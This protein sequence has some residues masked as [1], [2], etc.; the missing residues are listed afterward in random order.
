MAAPEHGIK[1][2]VE[3]DDEGLPGHLG[4]NQHSIAMVNHT[5]RMST[6]T[7]ILYMFLDAVVEAWEGS[8]NTRFS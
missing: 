1:H 5:V 3:E 7:L 4:V 6:P 2:L 8:G